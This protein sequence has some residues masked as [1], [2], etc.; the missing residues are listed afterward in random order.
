MRLSVN[1]TKSRV[2]AIEEC[3]F[4]GFTFR[5]TKLRWSGRAFGDFLRR[6]KG[7]SNRSWGVSM[8]TRFERL[9]QYLRGWM[10]YYGISDYYRPI[11]DLDSWLR[12]RVR[13]CSW[14]QWRRRHWRRRSRMKPSRGAGT[15]CRPH[16]RH[17][18]LM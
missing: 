5:G 15:Q 1:E 8:E 13:M 18:C 2:A 10:G 9:A 17:G 16:G 14:K 7:L 11:P 4:L 12:R 6:I 3:V